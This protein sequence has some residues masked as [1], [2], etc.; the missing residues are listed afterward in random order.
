MFATKLSLAAFSLLSAACAVSAAPTGFVPEA[1]L[2]E[3]GWD[4][5]V[6]TP[7]ELDPSN[8]VDTTLGTLAGSVFF[9]TDA[10]FRGRCVT[11]SGFSSGQCVGVG[12]DFNDQVTSFRPSSGLS[13]TIYS[14]AG[15]RGRATGG[16]V[17]PG[18]NNLADFNNNDAMSSFRC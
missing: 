11:V 17:A 13:C 12:A 18:I 5:K 16:V 3:L 6:T 8:V 7:A 1:W 4:G 10:N 2:T 9:C 15:C 14:D